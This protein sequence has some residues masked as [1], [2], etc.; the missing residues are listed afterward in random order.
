V[1]F[2]AGEDWTDF[3]GFYV[4]AVWD[5]VDAVYGSVR[6]SNS[7]VFPRFHRASTFLSARRQ[8]DN[9][10]A[11]FANL[12]S[13]ESLL[14]LIQDLGPGAL[15]LVRRIVQLAVDESLEVLYQNCSHGFGQQL[16]F[17]SRR[18]ASHDFSE[19]VQLEWTVQPAGVTCRVHNTA[20]LLVNAIEA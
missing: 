16:P 14:K 13:L 8:V 3:I 9:Q 1:H 7:I 2:V 5:A 17:G 15:K 11:S 18:L 12:Q 6:R 19:P 10:P 20:A 4:N